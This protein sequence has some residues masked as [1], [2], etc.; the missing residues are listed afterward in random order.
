MQRYVERFQQ[1]GS[2]AFC[3]KKNGPVLTLNEFDVV[4]L[5]QATLNNPGVCLRELQ[6]I[7]QSTSGIHVNISTIWRELKRQ[8]WVIPK[9][10]PTSVVDNI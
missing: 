9:Y 7:L 5:V 6:Q 1:T 4:I 8:T 10:Q 2:V 3:V